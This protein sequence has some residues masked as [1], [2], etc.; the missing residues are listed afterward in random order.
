MKKYIFGFLVLSIV[1][2]LSWWTFASAGQNENARGWLWGGGAEPDNA[3]PYDGSN[4][5]VGWI[6]ANNLSSGGSVSYGVS[7]PA[8]NGPVTGY[9]WSEHMGWINFGPSSGAVPAGSGC[10]NG[11]SRSGNDLVGCARFVNIETALGQGNSGGWSGWIKMKGSTYGVTVSAT[12]TSVN[13]QTTY[14]LGGYAWSEELGWVDF[15][16]MSVVVAGGNQLIVCPSTL[17][18]FMGGASQTL[19]ARYFEAYDGTADC[20]LTTGYTTPSVGWTVVNTGVANLSTPTGSTTNVSPT[21]VGNTVVTATYNGIT[22]NV[23]VVVAVVASGCGPMG[24][25]KCVSSAPT[26]GLC[27]AGNTPS[28]VSGSGPWSWTCTGAGS[29]QPVQCNVNECSGG[30]F[31]EVTP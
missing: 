4:T 28:A 16:R 6:S 1:T 3:P 31:K 13:N 25:Q 10:A 11:V 24:S 29:T 2:C 5:N 12:G 15:S 20:N 7:I 23:P 14:P 21:G 9:A 8:A 30:P 22:R 18:F 27:A 17:T 26:T 19:R